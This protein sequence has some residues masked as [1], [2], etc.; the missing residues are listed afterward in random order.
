MDTKCRKLKANDDQVVTTL[1]SFGSM[2][3][4]NRNGDRQPYF[5]ERVV[6][7]P[8]RIPRDC[9]TK[10]LR[11]ANLNHLKALR[12]CPVK[13]GCI[14]NDLG[15][16]EKENADKVQPTFPELALLYVRMF[17]EESDKIERGA[18][19]QARNLL[20]SSVEF[21]TLQEGIPPKPK[22]NKNRGT[23][24]VITKGS[25]QVYRGHAGT[26]PRLQ[27]VTSLNLPKQIL[28]AQTEA[29]KPENSRTKM[30]EHPIVTIP[31]LPDFGGVTQDIS[32]TILEAAKTLSKVASQ[33]VSKISTGSTKVDS[34]SASKRGQK[35][36]KA[37]IVEEEIHGTYKTKEQIRQ[38]EARLEDAI[39]LQAQ[40]DEEVAKQIHLDEMV[41]KR[42][43]EEEALLEQ[44]K[45]R[46]SQVQIEAQYYTEEDW[47]AIKAKLEANAELTKDVLGK[48]LPDQDFAKRMVDMIK[49]SLIVVQQID[50]FVMD[51]EAT[52]AK[53]KRYG[54]EL[55]TKTSKK[56]KI[57]DKDVP[58][59]GEKVD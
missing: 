55:Q 45:K 29:R 22:D 50:T 19:G 43:A 48:D 54:E 15:R 27:R 58:A 30:L 40:M 23:Q 16:S 41:A 24:L 3:W 1:P 32:P 12:S 10:T 37:P 51:F 52:K 33:G 44:Q 34:S 8:E 57:D 36:G 28:D 46:K 18:L 13:D 17:P 26:E 56:Q 21:K 39:K 7:G 35:E 6:E 14:C 5:R 11:I 31:L 49:E 25:S 38:E 53:L 59:I 4:Q 42:M 47:D 20:A 2:Y 9:L